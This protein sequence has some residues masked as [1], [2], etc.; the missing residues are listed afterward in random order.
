MKGRGKPT[1]RQKRKQQNVIEDKKPALRSK[2][3][4]EE[5][6]RKE[7]AQEAKRQKLETVPRALHRLYQ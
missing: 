3:Q 2:L 7:A 5:R 6:S 4:E 1:R